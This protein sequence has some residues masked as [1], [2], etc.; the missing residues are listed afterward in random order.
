MA[1][2]TTEPWSDWDAENAGF[3]CEIGVGLTIADDIAEHHNGSRWMSWDETVAF[4]LWLGKKIE[5][6]NGK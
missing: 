6:A 2:E 4:Y 1:T 3:E 5:A